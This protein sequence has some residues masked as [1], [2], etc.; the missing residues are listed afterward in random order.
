MLLLLAV[1]VVVFGNST[2]ASFTTQ[3]LA[4][5]TLSSEAAGH[6]VLATATRH[7]WD[8]NLSWLVAKLLVIFG[9]VFLLA[10]T[11]LRKKYEAWLDRGVNAL[12]WVGLGVG[13]GAV[14]TTV[15]MLSGVSDVST[16]CLI[17]A[18]VALAG[19]L[20]AT[21]EFV[22]PGRHVRR[23]LAIGALVAVF[24]PWL[25][26][27]RTAGAVVMFDGS[28]P[29]YMYYLY[30]SGTLLVVAVALATGLRIKQRG[31]WADTF[32]TERMFMVLTFIVATIPALQIFA[33]A[34]QP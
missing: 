29:M 31:K 8:V 11:L 1:A 30:A 22:G 7:L 15:A 10:A 20:T 27:V 4:K 19:L 34:L 28:L 21:I 3:Y 9:V 25:I 12:R 18:S 13:G 16:L 26:F 24:V 2:T 14:F 6:E 33:G 23:L 5:D 17:F 32:Y